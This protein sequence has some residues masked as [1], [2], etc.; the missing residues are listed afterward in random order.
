MWTCDGTWSTRGAKLRIEVTL[1]RTSRSATP[2]AAQQVADL[3][4]QAGVTSILNF[5]PRVL[6]VPAQVHLRYVD[7]SIELQVLGFYRARREGPDERKAVDSGQVP[8]IRSIGL[9]TSSDLG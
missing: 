8:L 5:A 4:V 2:W 7:L 9:S 6:T 1:A 3:L